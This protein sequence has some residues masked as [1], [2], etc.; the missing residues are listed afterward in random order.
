MPLKYHIEYDDTG[1]E[2]VGGQGG[3]IWVSGIGYSGIMPSGYT[4]I[5]H[6]EQTWVQDLNNAAISGLYTETTWDTSIYNEYVARI[7][8]YNKL[9]EDVVRLSGYIHDLE[10]RSYFYQP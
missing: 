5:V 1:Y 4:V 3:G 6:R 2:G 7:A 9:V 8:D 10:G